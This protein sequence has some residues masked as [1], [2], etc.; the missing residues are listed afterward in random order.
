MRDQQR[1]TREAR[2]VKRENERGMVLRDRH[3]D[4]WKKNKIMA[5]RERL[6]LIKAEEMY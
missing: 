2:V 1:D 5:W 4:R 3:Q 6:E